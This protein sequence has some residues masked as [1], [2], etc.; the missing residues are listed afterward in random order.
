[1]SVHKDFISNVGMST[2]CDKTP[3]GVEKKRHDTICR[4][5]QHL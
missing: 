4:L 2:N 3:S 1:M 5:S